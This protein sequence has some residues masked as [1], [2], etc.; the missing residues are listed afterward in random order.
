MSKVRRAILASPV[1]HAAKVV[2]ATASDHLLVCAVSNWGGAA[3]G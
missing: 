1:P 3:L 2:A